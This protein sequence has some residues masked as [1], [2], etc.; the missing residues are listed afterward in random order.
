MKDKNFL[1]KFVEKKRNLNFSIITVVLNAEEYLEKTILN[2]KNQKFKNF[3]YIVVY[4]PSADNTWN[5]ILKYRKF[6]DK[7]IINKKIGVYPPMNLGIKFAK[8]K[9][10]NFLNS[11]DFFYNYKT[12]GEVNKKL[13]LNKD[14]IYGDSSVYYKNYEKKISSL[15]FQ[16]IYYGMIFSHQS[17]FIKLDILKKN[18]F[19]LKYLYASDYNQIL[20]IYNKGYKFL[21]IEKILSISKSDGI[22]DKNR[23][24]TIEENLKIVFNQNKK[25][26]FFALLNFIYK[27]N[28][29]FIV[30]ILKKILPNKLFI[31]I[32]RLLNE[33]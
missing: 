3:E 9:Y 33:K 17:C 25:K 10:V 32:K 23:F 7:I 16:K 24:L 31:K 8:G 13:N 22:A 28:Y 21:K 5:I 11:G 1:Y 6:I 27:Y 20:S 19:N 12:L 2:V 15:S 26:F 30:L 4:T 18:L 29:F 14:V